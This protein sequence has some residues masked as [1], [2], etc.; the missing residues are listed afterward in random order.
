MLII[1]VLFHN[2]VILTQK[3]ACP[4]RVSKNTNIAGLF[5][6]YFHLLNGVSI[7]KIAEDSI[8]TADLRCWKQPLCQLSHNH[9]PILTTK[10]R[11]FVKSYS[12][13]EPFSQKRDDE[14]LKRFYPT[15]WVRF[16]KGVLIPQAPLAAIKCLGQVEINQ[17]S[18][19]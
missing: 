5:Y 18:M 2:A 15:K 1:C 10:P 13:N 3:Y 6:L 17:Q 14:H 8:C 7:K 19:L 4:V 9:C 12:Q 11:K 16:E